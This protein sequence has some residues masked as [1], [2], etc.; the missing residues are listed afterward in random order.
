[1]EYIFF[2]AAIAFYLYRA[3]TQAQKKA[4]A[5]TER[6]RK[7]NEESR[8]ASVPSIP[9]LEEVLTEV[10]REAEM[11]TKPF[12]EGKTLST[13]R[14]KVARQ[15]QKKMLEQSRTPLPATKKVALKKKTSAP[16]LTSDYTAETIEPEGTP[17]QSMQDFI[18][19]SQ[20]TDA[21]ALGKKKTPTTTFNLRE[22]VIAK[23]ILDRPEW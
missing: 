15:E 4:K 16:F 19:E 9:T 11:K 12:G 1:M 13:D 6:R 21:Y 22:A 23:I 20:L 2:A 8:P 18:K 3:F 14:R 10:F 7:S 5:D 17:S